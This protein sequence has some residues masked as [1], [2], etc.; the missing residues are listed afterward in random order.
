M[1]E[2]YTNVTEE[3]QP[4]NIRVEDE[5][6]GLRTTNEDGQNNEIEMLKKRIAE[7][8]QENAE[9]S[10]K[11]TLNKAAVLGGVPTA[12]TGAVTTIMNNP[13]SRWVLLQT[14]VS[15]NIDINNNIAEY[16]FNHGVVLSRANTIASHLAKALFAVANTL[17][18]YPAII[19]IAA[20]VVVGGL[21]AITARVI[22]NSSLK[23]KN[24]QM[25]PEQEKTL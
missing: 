23:H 13:A 6:T 25:K 1:E 19:P 5:N 21:G 16:L 7:L 17:I 12:V 15:K 20:S 3:Q 2:N 14:I 10:R 11:N 8:E 18:N 4:E 22:A 9:L 24:L